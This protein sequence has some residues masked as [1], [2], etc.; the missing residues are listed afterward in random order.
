MQ[1]AL[2]TMP[3]LSFHQMEQWA[4]LDDFCKWSGLR[5]GVNHGDNQFMYPNYGSLGN[6]HNFSNGQGNWNMRSWNNSNTNLP[7]TT[8]TY[9][10]R[11]QAMVGE[12]N[13]FPP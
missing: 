12:P 13:R 8:S 10:P 11:M 2:T 1:K 4:W 5:R 6:I 9:N 3:V 7:W